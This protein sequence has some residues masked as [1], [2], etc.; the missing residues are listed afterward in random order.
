MVYD[1]VSLETA[2]KL[3]KGGCNIVCNAYYS[4]SMSF[5]K[6]YCG[7]SMT[8]KSYVNADMLRHTGNVP[9]YKTRDVLKWLKRKGYAVT[10]KWNGQTWNVVIVTSGSTYEYDSDSV[11]EEQAY[12]N[13]IDFVLDKISCDV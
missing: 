4:K 9:C 6:V 1:V 7:G 3:M 8:K 5:N 2:R 13:A 11:K 10:L 12:A